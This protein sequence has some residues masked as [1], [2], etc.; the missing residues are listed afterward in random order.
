[1]A[2]AQPIPNDIPKKLKT[3]SPAFE[4][5]G[6]LG[7]GAVA[8]VIGVLC[9]FPLDLSKTRLQKQTG[10]AEYSGIADCLKKVYM[11]DG[12]RGCY[13][14]MRANLFG[15]IPEKAIKL[16]VNDQLRHML[17]DPV[18]GKLSIGRELLAGAGAGFCQVVVT[19]P[20]EIIK[21]RGQLT[22]ASITQVVA[23]LGVLGLYKGYPPTLARDVW[24]S[25]IFFPMQAKLKERV[26]K[27]TDTASEQMTKSFLCAISTA[28]FAAALS[29]PLDVVKTRIQAG[30]PGGMV[31]VFKQTIQT[32]GYGALFKGVGPRVIAIGPL[33]GI[34][35]MV[36]DLQKKVVRAMGYEA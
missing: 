15:I 31:G 17:K 9:T 23:D 16:A 22:G 20:M 27:P 3:M 36:Y 13:S 14:G 35:M 34:A 33:F 7:A 10:K 4:F 5:A 30:I 12:I 28:G 18:T 32:E 29:T 21:I 26:V 6:R 11:R 19:T 1:M 24:F 2:A 8:G 25:V